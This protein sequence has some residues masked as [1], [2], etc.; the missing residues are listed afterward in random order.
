M[1]II[2]MKIKTL[3]EIIFPINNYNYSVDR[4]FVIVVR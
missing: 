4:E 3:I 1:T 2:F